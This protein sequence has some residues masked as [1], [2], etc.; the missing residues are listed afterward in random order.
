MPAWLIS[1][2]KWIAITFIAPMIQKWVEQWH[3]QRERAKKLK[4]RITKNEAKTEAYEKD[5]SDSNFDQLP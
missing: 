5:P 3:K 2:L 4:D 1:V